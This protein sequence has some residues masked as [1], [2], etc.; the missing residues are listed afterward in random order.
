L[1]LTKK[2]EPREPKSVLNII[3]WIQFMK[4]ECN[5]LE[6]EKR[7]IFT[8]LIA[9]F[10]F[11]A[12]LFGMLYNLL[13]DQILFNISE[14]DGNPFEIKMVAISLV[15]VVS[16]QIYKIIS[17]F[18]S[19]LFHSRI[20]NVIN[21]P[22]EFMTSERVNIIPIVYIFIVLLIHRLIPNV[23]SVS[24]VPIE[25]LKS[26]TYLVLILIT[27]LESF[28]IIII[29]IFEKKFSE[30]MEKELINNKEKLNFSFKI[31]VLY[32]IFISAL[33][34]L[35]IINVNW[36]SIELF[37]IQLKFGLVFM[38]ILFISI[39]W[40]KPLSLRLNVIATR[41]EQLQ[42]LI[43]EALHDEITKPEDIILRRDNFKMY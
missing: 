32:Q 14:I 26:L 16:F 29:I 42:R 15:F 39:Y 37:I 12:I 22:K 34:I 41:I 11:V 8:K 36:P 25:T 3:E 7:F 40:G 23:L 2:P 27:G 21:L 31:G 1:N 24:I 28:L 9:L 20:Y 18:Y 38:L 19:I 35:V 33:I 4:D 10:T 13:T 5:S 43:D 17:L 6:E 30:S